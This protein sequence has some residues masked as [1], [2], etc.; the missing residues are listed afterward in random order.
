MMRRRLALGIAAMGYAKLVVMIVQLAMV[1]ALAHG[2]G[3]TLYGQWLVLAAIP[4]FLAA[5]DLGFGM[6]A[7]NRMVAEIAREETASAQITFQSALMLIA[8]ACATM[9]AL[10][11]AVT[12]A[13]PNRLFAVQ[14]GMDAPTAR[15]VL[16]LLSGFAGAT[17]FMPLLVGAARAAGKLAQATGLTATTHL[18]ES[19]SVIALVL[20]GYGPLAA[21]TAMAAIRVVAMA[22]LALYAAGLGEWAVA[23][24][25][26]ASQERLRELL[27]PG[28]AA[29]VLPLSQAGYLQGTA[30]AV[31][32]AGGLALVPVYTAVRTISRLTVQMLSALA[33][34]V[35]PE[36]A[37]ARARGE[38]VIASRLAGALALVCLVVGLVMAV[39]VAFGGERLLDLWTGGAIT[40]PLPMIWLF[41]GAVLLQSLWAP[42]SDLLLALNRH[43]G[44]SYAY[45]LLAVLTV[46][47]TLALVGALGV[48]GAAAANL[49]LEGAMVVVVSLS[50]RRWAGPICLSPG[51]LLT[52]LLR[53]KSA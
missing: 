25:R 38:D 10:V 3:L 15:H 28:L 6:A 11:I 39:I 37:A 22:G 31:G 5:S 35:M 43:E 32:A 2:W 47:L 13:L 34:P 24:F 29:M 52:M 45:L 14:G 23:G 51:V 21:A 30:I 17:L 50:L 44:Y 41:A 19:M 9:L 26:A 16:W 46:P 12:S 49:M 36:F 4:V 33:I 1:P 20:A 48:T 18:V 27:R 7:G 42:M 53:K 40:A 8:L